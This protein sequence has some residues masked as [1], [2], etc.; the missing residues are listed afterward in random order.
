MGVTSQST[1]ASI[2]LEANVLDLPPVDVLVKDPLSAIGLRALGNG[3]GGCVSEV[4]VVRK[5][6]G[7]IASNVKSIGVGVS[8]VCR[9]NEV[10]LE[11]SKV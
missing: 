7:L 5:R 6:P 1:L 2:L 10:S 9:R 11:L 8:V 4:K 3:G